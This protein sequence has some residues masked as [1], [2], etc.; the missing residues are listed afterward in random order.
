MSMHEWISNKM[1]SCTDAKW[2]GCE[3]PKLLYI[4]LTS[5]LILIQEHILKKIV[6]V[7]CI[8][9]LYPNGQTVELSVCSKITFQLP[10]PKIL[11]NI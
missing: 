7:Q 10:L 4:N 6:S 11:K 5:N 2:L 3:A 1:H 9:S 8:G